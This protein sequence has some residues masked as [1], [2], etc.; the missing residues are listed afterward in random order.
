MKKSFY[1]AVT[2]TGFALLSGVF[3]RIF[4]DQVTHFDG[5]TELNIVHV[6]LLAMGMLF[7]L[8][9]LVLDK[10]FDL[11]KLKEF[12]WFFWLYNSGLGLSV[13]MMLLIGLGQ[14]EGAPDS[15]ALAVVA[16][17]GHVTLTAGLVFFFIALYKRVVK[18]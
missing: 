18:R 13:F 17:L 4:V 12:D 9:V 16:G 10:L 14:V 7:F 1:A 6:H 8:L 2:Y 5:E 3:A 11:S 15:S